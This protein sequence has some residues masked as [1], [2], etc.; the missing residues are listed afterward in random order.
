M[1]FKSYSLRGSSTVHKLLVVIGF[2]FSLTSCEWGDQ[3]ESLV[4]PNPD[5][6]AVLYTDT[7]TVQLS[8]VGSDS[9]MT[10]APGRLLVGNYTDPYFGKVRAVTFIQPT[11]DGAINVATDAQY[12]SLILSLHYDKYSYGDTT[13]ALNLTVHKLLA[14]MLDKNSY[15]NENSTEYDPV[16]VGK[17]KV[18]AR[19]NTSRNIKIR[20]SDAIGKQLF[21]KAQ[22]NQLT[23]NDDWIEMVKGFAVM[24]GVNDN[25]PFIGFLKDSSSV[26]LHYHT[27][28]ISEFRKDSAI[29]RVTGRYNQIIG[30]RTGTQLAKLPSTKRIALPS[31]QSGNMA[32]IQNGTGIMTRI[33]FPYLKNLKSIKYTAAN[34]AFLRI[35]PLRASVTDVL[36]VP[37]LLFVYR[38]DKNNEFYQGGSGPLPLYELSAGS[39]PQQVVAQYTTDFVN[40]KQYYLLDVSAY[41]TDIM[42]SETDEVGGLILRAGPFSSGS[43][44]Q[45]FDT[46][47]SKSVNRMVIG[48]QQNSDPGVKLE[49]YYTTVKAQ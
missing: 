8:T 14:N 16:A 42:T 27:P 17:I 48:S 22:N 49:L 29:L 32:F 11:T 2:A 3:I 18:F 15:W 28:S 33:D 21:Q 12:D 31:A 38:A 19:P 37:S 7:V 4:Q 13:Q 1:K 23:S 43:G 40:N 5:D 25:S 9:L 34:R 41:V 45:D 6:F 26:Q 39:Q 24:N 36:K 30:N 44:F 20:L 10:G 47:V 46:E 35:T